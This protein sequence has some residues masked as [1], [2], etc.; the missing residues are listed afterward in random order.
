MGERKIYPRRARSDDEYVAIARVLANG[1]SRARQVRAKV[2]ASRL[3]ATLFDT[4]MWVKGFERALV[5]M[6]D[7]HVGRG[8]KAH[9]SL[10]RQPAVK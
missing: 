4:E 10:Q 7:V 9:I 1:G 5:A 3:G 8:A 2:E 6:W